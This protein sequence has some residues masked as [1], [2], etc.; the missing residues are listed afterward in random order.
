MA[1]LKVQQKR[2]LV[3]LKKNQRE[4]LRTLGLKRIGDVV[5]KEDRPE[6]RGMVNT[7]RHLVTVEE[8]E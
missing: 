6:I 2:G 1:Q 4:T 5:V 3:G 8:V 7:V